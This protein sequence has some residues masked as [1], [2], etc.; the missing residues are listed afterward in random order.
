MKKTMDQDVKN[1]VIKVGG[2]VASLPE[3]NHD[4]Y[5]EKFYR[6]YLETDRLSGTKDELPVIVSERLAN[7]QELKIGKTI[8]I[9]GEYRS[10]NQL[11]QNNKSRLVLFVFAKEIEQLE[12]DESVKNINELTAI[13]T[14]CKQPIY[15]KTPMG[16]EITDLFIAINR[17]YNKSDYV[18]CI[19]WGRNAKYCEKLEIGM[20][21]KI[22]GRIQSRGYEKKYDDG[23]IENRVAYE[24]S[25]SKFEI[26]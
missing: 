19:V 5:G 15:R 8:Y 1:N 9:E 4:V 20:T 23:Q 16:R 22:E 3:F 21:L 10:Y 7:L 24:V 2:K 17:S 14:I 12:V 6:F 13:G 18:P 26:L 11:A 25:V